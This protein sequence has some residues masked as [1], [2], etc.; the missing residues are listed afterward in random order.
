MCRRGL[1]LSIVGGVAVILAAC[2][3]TSSSPS[4]HTSPTTTIAPST[5]PV[6]TTTQ[7]SPSPTS[8]GPIINTWGWEGSADNVLQGGQVVYFP[9]GGALCDPG[10]TLTLTWSSNGNVEAFIL[11]SAQ[12]GKSV[13]GQLI[14]TSAAHGQGQSGSITYLVQNTDSY[15]A[16]VRNVY[17]EASVTLFQAQMTER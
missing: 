2:S 11:T 9:A 4:T 8:Q 16:I 15:F 6:Q 1:I 12:F 3:A 10:R 5:V 14:T 13:T 17:P 7:P